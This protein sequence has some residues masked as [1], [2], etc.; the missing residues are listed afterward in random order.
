[1]IVSSI[2]DL[3]EMLR[4]SDKDPETVI[5]LETYG[6]D[7]VRDP[8]TGVT[9]YFPN[10]E[11]G[12]YIPTGHQAGWRFGYDTLPE[13]LP[14]VIDNKIVKNHNLKFDKLF[15]QAEGAWGKPM[16]QR[17]TLMSL[18]IYNENED[19]FQLKDTC[20]RYGLGRGSLEEQVLM[21]KVA[22]LGYRGKK[23]WKAY[24][25]FL[26]PE[27]VAPYAIDDCI[28]AHELDKFAMKGIVDQNLM[29]IFRKDMK[30][31]DIICRAEFRGLH[32]DVDLCNER[33]I[34]CTDN[35]ESI[36]NK[37]CSLLDVS[38]FNPNSSPQVCKA[39]GVESSAKDKLEKMSHPIAK[40]VVEY[41]EWAKA[42]NSYYQ[43]FVDLVDDNHYLHCTIWPDG[44]VTA[45]LRVSNPPLQAMPRANKVH[46]EKDVF[47]A[48]PGRSLIFGDWNQMELRVASHYAKE[49]SMIKAFMDGVDVHSQTALL[50]HGEVTPETRNGVIGGKR[51]NF[52]IVYG[53]GAKGM[54][55]NTGLEINHC[56]HVLSK[57]HTA[58]PGFKALYSNAEFKA[59]MVGYIQ[60]YT[61]R[62]RRF[63]D[64]R[65]CYK[66]M[67]HLVQGTVA[68]MARDSMI[69]V[70]EEIINEYGEDNV[71]IPLQV[72]DELMLDVP[73]E[74][75][76][77][78]TPKLKDI[79]E[80]WKYLGKEEMRVPIVADMK[81]GHSW[82]RKVD[83][84][85]WL[86]SQ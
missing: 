80:D 41:R 61:G 50:V 10:M 62:R 77:E 48:E 39:L 1:M 2:E 40:M 37:I 85:K 57:L 5:D 63:P 4:W 7:W 33:V 16:E 17:C 70:D 38:T 69:R 12:F 11:K 46:R 13:Y 52:A 64:K 83:Y 21:E 68:E 58:Y 47:I 35:M 8:I 55:E 6:L 26:P 30:F 51:C 22:K 84:D 27:D 34:E 67:N 76:R 75:I 49:Y 72:H 82:G 18:Q 9:I 20:D 66:A 65:Q 31:W 71:Y 23:G 59:R 53:T 73:D 79:M 3:Q 74:L 28:L 56:K 43:K 86:S 81:V 24:M 60:Y 42:R 44:T 45:R 29:H 78:V 15:L 32:I 36:Q 19:N 54:S 25:R 14:K